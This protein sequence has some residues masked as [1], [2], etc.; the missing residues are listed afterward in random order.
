MVTR[1]Q[2]LEKALRD[3]LNE[4]SLYTE[5]AARDLVYPPDNEPTYCCCCGRVKTNHYGAMCYSCRGSD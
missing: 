4:R 3:L 5:K 1:E 2:Q